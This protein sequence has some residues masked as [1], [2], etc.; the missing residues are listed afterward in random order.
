MVHYYITKAMRNF[1]QC[2]IF[3]QSDFQEICVNNC[4]FFSFC[5]AYVYNTNVFIIIEKKL[6]I[7]YLIFN[8]KKS[9][10][11]YISSIIYCALFLLFILN[12]KLY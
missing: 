12:K 9:N 5:Y 1:I 3:L 11:H 2:G 10:V 7:E 6:V 4:N 8:G